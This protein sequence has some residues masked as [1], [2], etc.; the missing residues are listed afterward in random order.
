MKHHKHQPTFTV[1]MYMYTSFITIESKTF[2]NTF[3][4]PF[5]NTIYQTVTE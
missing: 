1:H 4:F 2:N 5:T 3:N